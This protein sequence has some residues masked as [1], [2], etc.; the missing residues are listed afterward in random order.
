MPQQVYFF[1]RESCPGCEGFRA[2]QDITGRLNG[3]LKKHPETIGGGYN[4]YETQRA[5]EM[6][7]KEWKEKRP[8]DEP[9][10]LPGLLLDGKPTY[11]YEE[12]E[13]N[14]VKLQRL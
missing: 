13:K 10:G 6:M 1:Y 4:L 14:L 5:D 2:A 8:Q 12:I 7:T 9:F 11:K 3:F